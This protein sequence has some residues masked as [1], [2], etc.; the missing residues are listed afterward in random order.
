MSNTYGRL[1]TELLDISKQLADI[2]VH[3]PDCLPSLNNMVRIEIDQE[4]R[5]ARINGVAM[6]KVLSTNLRPLKKEVD[7]FTLAERLVA[8]R[9]LINSLYILLTNQPRFWL[10]ELYRDGYVHVTEID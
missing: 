1:P 5:F 10:I 2:V 3:N 9:V 8:I 7:R 4:R 6:S